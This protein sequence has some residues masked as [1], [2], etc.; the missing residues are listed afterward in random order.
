LL[1][2]G[3]P[4]SAEVWD[5]T[6]LHLRGDVTASDINQPIAS[7]APDGLLQQQIATKLLATCP[8]VT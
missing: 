3:T 1:L 5:E 8:R 6:R 2:H 7:A 4:L